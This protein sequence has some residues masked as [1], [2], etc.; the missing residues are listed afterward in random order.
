MVV[1]MVYGYVLLQLSCLLDYVLCS[2]AVQ[3][4]PVAQGARTDA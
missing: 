2:Q 3:Q 4:F 1:Y